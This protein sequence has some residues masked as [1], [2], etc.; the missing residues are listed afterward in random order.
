VSNRP[1][2]VVVLAA[3]E[4]TRMKSATPKVLH[5]IG[6]R[7]L[8]A[9]A[10]AAARAVESE[11][12]LVV[13]GHGRD[14]VTAALGRIDPLARP[15]VQEQQLGTG[16]AVRVALDTVGE[17]A[18]TVVV[19]YG[20][21]PLLS[22][23]TL[24][25]LLEHHH[26]DGNAVTVLTA[27]VPDPT[28]YG[29]V[30]RDPDGAVAAIVEEKDAT[31][32]QRAAS[33]VNSGVYAF[34]AKLLRDALGRLSTDNAAGEEYLTDVPTLLRDDGHP[35]GAVVIRD[36]HE[37]L[38]VNDRVQLAELRRLLNERVLTR[39][40]CAG[41][42]VVDPAS[43]WID[44][45]VTLEPDA[46]LLPNTQLHGATH[47]SGQAEVGP[48]STLR[49]TWVGAGASVVCTHATGAEIGPGATV[50]PFTYL[51]PGARLAAKAKAG[52][53]V[54][55]KNA[56]VGA[57]SKVPHLS[58]VGD[59]TIGE[60]ANIGAATVFVNYDGQDKHRTTVGDHVRVGSDT[61]LVAPVTVGDG[62]YTAAG[63]V[64]TDDVPP[65]ALAIARA[66]QRNVDG[67]VSRRRPGSAA[68]RAAERARAAAESGSDQSSPE[69]PPQ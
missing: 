58:Y 46:V 65:G 28:G 48:N 20:D 27:R 54:E 35:V 43:T 44:V 32:D 22:G 68:A 49:D 14:Q 6:G 51:R 69:E 4:G 31:D 7:P 23:D 67:W 2:A 61:M 8:L 21:V 25:T 3:G 55:I 38:G 36:H 29:R 15:V 53:Y 1:A 30:V 64:V 11:H 19:T 57:G 33:E 63:S 37:V 41:V 40:M 56:E 12:L 13:V 26:R 39:W 66:R 24:G 9:H 62:A 5:E 47:V 10:L 45:G 34:D 60:G 18:G 59:A 42:T 16:H 17:L 52:A 50:G